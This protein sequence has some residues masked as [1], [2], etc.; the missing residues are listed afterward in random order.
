MK[1]ATDRVIGASKIARDISERKRS[2]AQRELLFNEI[3][4]RVKNTLATVQAIAGQTMRSASKTELEAFASRLHALGSAYDVLTSE[5]W[6]RASMQ[7]I[8]GRAI[9]P[10]QRDR[11]LAQGPD[12]HLNANQ[13]LKLT[14]V[15]HELAT[16]AVKYGALSNATGSVGIA[17]QREDRKRLKLTW[18]ETGGPPV[19]PPTHKGFGSML[20]EQSLDGV[21]FQFA[22]TGVTCVLEIA[23]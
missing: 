20:I 22:A 23:L 1:D 13:S 10:F 6:D 18:Q 5:T 7:D 14:M 19:V 17:W 9:E 12:V 21:S 15:L 4:H 3:K 16:N 2:E 11:F 8:V